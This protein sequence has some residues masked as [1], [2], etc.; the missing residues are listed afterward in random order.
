MI[1]H[2]VISKNNYVL[3]ISIGAAVTGLSVMLSLFVLGA[4]V[5]IVVVV[6]AV[7]FM[8]WKGILTLTIHSTSSKSVCNYS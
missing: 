4:V 5:A 2:M 3:I 1:I 6:A 7:I 8:K